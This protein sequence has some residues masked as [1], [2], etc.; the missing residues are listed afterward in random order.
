MRD[1]SA[2]ASGK[3]ITLELSDR[4]ALIL[5]THIA[6]GHPQ[7]LCN[8]LTTLGLADPEEATLG[9]LKLTL[10]D[11]AEP[12]LE[13]LARSASRQVLADLNHADLIT[14]AHVIDGG[15]TFTLTLKEMAILAAVV[16]VNTRGTLKAGIASILGDVRN[17]IY[18]FDDDALIDLAEPENR[19]IMRA[20]VAYDRSVLERSE[21]PP[22]GLIN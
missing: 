14:F 8:L 19:E 7:V 11:N 17:A 6:V 20:A 22:E 1:V 3:T 9:L 16:A 13:G 10:P 21:R 5:G 15:I 4:A 2:F 12:A 18:R